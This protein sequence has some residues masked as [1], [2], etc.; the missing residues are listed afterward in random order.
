MIARFDVT[1]FI[2]FKCNLKMIRYEYL[3]LHRWLRRLYWDESEVTKGAFKNT[4]FFDLVS[5][6]TSSEGQADSSSVQIGIY[7]SSRRETN[8][9]GWTCSRYSAAVKPAMREKNA[10]RL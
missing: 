3:N 1:Y 4:T 9:T 10:L 5:R 7:Q 6:S 8:R 2:I